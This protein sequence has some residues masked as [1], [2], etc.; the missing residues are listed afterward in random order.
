M[1]LKQVSQWV[2]RFNSIKKKKNH[3]TRGNFVVVINHIVISGQLKTGRGCLTC[4]LGTV[5]VI[6]T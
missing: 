4:C 2:S 1:T 6:N 3:P 5:P